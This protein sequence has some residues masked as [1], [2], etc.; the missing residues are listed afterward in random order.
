LLRTIFRDVDLTFHSNRKTTTNLLPS[1]N[2]R[3]TATRSP[4]AINV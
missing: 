2:I 4:A 3:V 1:N